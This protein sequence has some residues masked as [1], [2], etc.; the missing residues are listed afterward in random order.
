MRSIILA[1]A[2][3]IAA[4]AAENQTTRIYIEPLKGYESYIAAAIVKKHVPVV[5]TEDRDKADFVITSAVTEKE[6][7]T[8]SKIARCLFAYCAGIEGNQT[9]SIRLINPRTKEVIFAYNVRKAGA[10]NYQSSSEAVAKHLK[11]FLTQKPQ[12]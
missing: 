2:L 10:A 5:V 4:Y 7:T 6:E 8:G 1:L 9:V 3:T 11:Q 12:A